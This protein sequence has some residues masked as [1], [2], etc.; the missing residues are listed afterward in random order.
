MA[1]KWNNSKSV[2]SFG[3]GVKVDVD[4]WSYEMQRCK[5]NTTHGKKKTTSNNIINKELQRVYDLAE[6]IFYN[7][8]QK[9]INP[10]ITEFKKEFNFQMGKIR[11]QEDDNISFFKIYED[12]IAKQSIINSWND[13]MCV[14]F[15]S[16]KK[17]LLNF[18]KDI[19]FSNINEDYCI[20]LVK[21]M[22]SV[23]SM[24]LNKKDATIGMRNTTIAKT[25]SFFKMFLRWAKKNGYYNGTA[26]EDFRPKLKGTDGNNKEVIYLTWNELIRLYN[27]DFKNEYHKRVR[28]VF[29]FCCFS[30]LRYSDAF[31]LRK[32]DIKNDCISIVTKKTVE[33]L[34]IELNKYS[35]AILDR[36][37]DDKT[38][39]ALPVISNQ[40]MNDYLKEIGEINEPQRIVYFVGNQRYE[41]VHPKYDLLTTHCGR[42]TFIVNS[43]YLGIPAE[44]VMKWTGHSD[45]DSMKP[46]IKI[47]DELKI[48]SM[49]KFDEK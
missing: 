24:K 40:Q 16:L 37:K 38:E 3:V 15:N 27:Y 1:L 29:C 11:E 39:K 34:K 26:H 18:D 14:K 31:N 32:N 22:Q 44:V 35:R 9:E 8:E 20:R 33:S 45:Y 19:E 28:D 42:R 6:N 12:Y 7:F 49:K 43:L 4:K 30:S 46:Y 48:D 36:Y 5:N 13:A 23:S 10:T 25:I 47:V 41:E 21:Y 2:L 17:H